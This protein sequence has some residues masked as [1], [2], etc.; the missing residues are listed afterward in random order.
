MKNV[1]AAMIG[2]M[3]SSMAACGEVGDA[4]HPI[5]LASAGAGGAGG[6][7]SQHQ[8]DAD[9]VPPPFPAA[10]DD[11]GLETKTGAIHCAIAGPGG[12]L[13][14]LAYRPDSPP[15]GRD[16]TGAP[17]PQEVNIYTA[18]NK[19]G[20]C[21]T[22]P[23]NMMWWNLNN[24]NGWYGWSYVK[25]IE[26]GSAVTNGWVCYGPNGTVGCYPLWAGYNFS[27][28][29]PTYGPTQPGWQSI[30]VGP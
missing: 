24:S 11:S 28:D 7:G 16:C 5:N 2:F 20:F 22:L 18:P 6:A 26:V 17:G 25:D 9:R 27:Y 30:Y 19:G 1:L 21:S 4:S 14:C 13:S 3:V 23:A 12:L 15:G 8:A 29:A 10:S